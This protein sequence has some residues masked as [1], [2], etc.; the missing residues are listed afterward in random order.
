MLFGYFFRETFNLWKYFSMIMMN[1]CFQ[2]FWKIPLTGRN[3]DVSRDDVERLICSAVQNLT[4]TWREHERHFLVH[5]NTSAQHVWL[6][7]VF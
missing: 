7:S 1:I 5:L 6:N 2:I 3:N 4:L